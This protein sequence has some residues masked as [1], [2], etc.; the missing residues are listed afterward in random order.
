M[1][2]KIAVFPLILYLWLGP[3]FSADY[4]NHTQER[5]TDIFLVKIQ[6]AN[7]V[8]ADR[9]TVCFYKYQSDVTDRLRGAYKAT[10]F[11]F[12]SAVGLAPGNEFL[13]YLSRDDARQYRS[14][15]NGDDPA[16]TSRCEKLMQGFFLL[17]NEINRVEQLWDGKHFVRAVQFSDPFA[18]DFP[19]HEIKEKTL[20]LVDYQ[21]VAKRL[22]GA[23]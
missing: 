18:D 11:P 5:Y 10:E 19:L 3:A 16:R 6:S 2:G 21:H 1:T 12:F 14:E 15:G 23:R 13:I 22:A 8:L 9:K 17:Y 20:H 7:P 4:L